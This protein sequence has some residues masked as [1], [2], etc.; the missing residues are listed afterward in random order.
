MALKL[1]SRHTMK[2]P[3]YFLSFLLVSALSH[4]QS[5]PK[6]Q[7]PGR[8]VFD[9][10]HSS[11]KD[12]NKKFGNKSARPLD[13]RIARSLETIASNVEFLEK[14]MARGKPVPPEY[15]EGVVLDA[16]LLKKLAA[17]K[18]GTL[19]DRKVLY[20][21]LQ[22]VDSD[23]AIK[24]AGP[25]SGG[26]IAR[27]VEVFVHAK[28]GADDVGAYQVWYVNKGWAKDPSRFKP[29]DRLTDPSNPPSMKLAPGNY[30]IWLSKGTPVTERQPASI[31]ENGESQRVI[32][33][34]V[35]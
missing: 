14:V 25:R 34:Q 29:F 27:V 33:L 10:F 8:E 24:V 21:G 4:A 11:L 28:K 18:S 35:P 26:D 2:L 31:G 7:T 15:L 6:Q 19:R 12:L 3:V 32:H 16:E 20:A 23:L 30:F 1:S 9:S 17:Q 22:E 5:P 13:A